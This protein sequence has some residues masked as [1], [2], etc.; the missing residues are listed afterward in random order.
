MAM[1]LRI[2]CPEKSAYEGEAAFVTLPTT[3]GELGVASRHASEI[4]T[5]SSG[6]IRVCDTAMGTVDRRFAVSGGYAQIADDEVIVLAERA[7]DVGSIQADQVQAKLQGFEDQ[8]SVLSENDARRA[9]LYNEI[10]WC[11]LLLDA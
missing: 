10:A 11:R 4:C 6:Y 8:L 5:L 1:M 2:V 7:A 9:Y 3:D